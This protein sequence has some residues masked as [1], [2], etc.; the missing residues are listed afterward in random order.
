MNKNE[1]RW[2]GECH[3]DVGWSVSNNRCE[4]C[5]EET[6]DDIGDWMDWVCSMEDTMVEVV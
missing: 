4:I 2:C 3:R 5:N 1:L 6:W